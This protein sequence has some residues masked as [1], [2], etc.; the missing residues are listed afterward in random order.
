[1]LKQEGI[2]LSN[3]VIIVHGIMEFIL[4]IVN[5]VMI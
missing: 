4:A 1:M 5:H 2:D 3:E